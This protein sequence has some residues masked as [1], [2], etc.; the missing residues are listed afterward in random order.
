M[1]VNSSLVT[2]LDNLASET[3]IPPER[4]RA[5]IR[6]EAFAYCLL[7][8]RGA[9]RRSIF[10]VAVLDG[11]GS[12]APDILRGGKIRLAGSQIDYVSAGGTQPFSQG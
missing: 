10:G 3:G 11:R 8:T 12:R 5:E 1:T 9:R 2:F 7:Q 4:T 6:R